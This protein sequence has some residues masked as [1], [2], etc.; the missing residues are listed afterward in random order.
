MN[1]LR[2]LPTSPMVPMVFERQKKVKWTKKL[3]S[4]ILSF[5]I[6]IILWT[7]IVEA[8]GFFYDLSHPLSRGQDDLGAGLILFL[9]SI[10]IFLCIVPLIVP[11]YKYLLKRLS[12]PSGGK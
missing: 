10:L 7:I 2:K 11:L 5:V 9:F 6:L 4:L 8:V 12:K 3:W 1:R